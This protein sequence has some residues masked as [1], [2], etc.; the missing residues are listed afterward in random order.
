MGD[1]RPSPG[2]DEVIVSP[3]WGQRHCARLEHFRAQRRAHAVI[4]FGPLGPAGQAILFPGCSGRSYPV[5]AACL[6][7]T[8]QLAATRWAGLT[9]RETE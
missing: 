7:A 4:T 3:P 5:C 1:L 2:P 6:A 9:L 8:R